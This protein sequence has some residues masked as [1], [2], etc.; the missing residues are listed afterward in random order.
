LGHSHAALGKVVVTVDDPNTHIVK[1]YRYLRIA[2]VSL[3][4][5]LGVAVAHEMIEKKGNCFQTSISAYWYTPAQA[6]FVGTL[7]AIGVCLIALKGNTEWED[8]FLN[9]A[10]ML[11]PFVAL[12]PTPGPG[13]CQTVKVDALERT[14]AVENNVTALLAVGLLGVV[15]AAFFAAR[16][17]G[18]A[19]TSQFGMAVAALILVGAA[20]WFWTDRDAFIGNA[21]Y[22]AALTM[23]GFIILV[24]AW[25][26][27]QFARHT[28]DDVATIDRREYAT[29]RYAIV[30][31]AMVGSLVLMGG[32]A[33]L[34]DW[35][36][37]VLW[38]EGVL[39]TLFAIFWILQ[40]KELWGEGIR[41]EDPAAPE[42]LVVA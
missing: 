18:T 26:A 14:A 8:I 12:V 24:V 34:F 39:I 1:T 35:D 3:V 37:A 5:A 4:V 28:T 22:T 29:N 41:G 31:A 40:T 38:I 11:A 27:W 13:K 25:N 23:F 16:S 9:C 42:T 20:I 10:G 6:I 30:A 17:S 36:H 33:W 2:M 7:I 32:Y 19:R 21:H 15:L